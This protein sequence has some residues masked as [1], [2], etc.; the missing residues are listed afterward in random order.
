MVLGS[1]EDYGVGMVLRQCG[2]EVE[3]VEGHARSR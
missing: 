3:V 2:D 1:L